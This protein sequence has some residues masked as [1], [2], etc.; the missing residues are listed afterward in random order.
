MTLYLL[1]K[2][3]RKMLVLY[4]HY[5]ESPYFQTSWYEYAVDNQ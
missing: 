5:V 2:T 4:Y 1:I 3:P